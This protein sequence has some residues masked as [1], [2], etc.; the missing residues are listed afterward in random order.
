MLTVGA[1]DA[2][3]YERGNRWLLIIACFNILLYVLVKVYYVRRNRQRD[4]IWSAMSEDQRLA[5]LAT[6]TDEGNKRLDFRFSH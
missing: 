6:T 4:R 3:R 2:P 1:D 5:Y